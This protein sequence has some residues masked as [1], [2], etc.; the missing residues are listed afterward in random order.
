[1]K[2]IFYLAFICL[3]FSCADKKLDIKTESY[4]SVEQQN[5]L[6]FD[7]VRYIEKLPKYATEQNKFDTIFDREYRKLADKLE[8]MYAYKNPEN[9][10]LFFAIAK[11]APSLKVKKTV[12]AGKLVYDNAGKLSYYEERFRT[13]K[14]DVLTLKTESDKLFQKYI[15]NQDLTPYYTKNSQGKFLIEFP[16]DNNTFDTQKRKWVFKPN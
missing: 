7:V 14:M 13:W 3:A 15:Q 12:T 5:K 10:T 4:L 9:D 2:N 6:K 11:V 1:M 16:D 8:V